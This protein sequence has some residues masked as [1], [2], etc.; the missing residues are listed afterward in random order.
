MRKARELRSLMKRQKERSASM[1]LVSASVSSALCLTW[2]DEANSQDDLWVKGPSWVR[3]MM[4][5]GGQVRCLGYI[6]PQGLLSLHRPACPPGYQSQVSTNRRCFTPVGLLACFSQA[7]GALGY[8]Q[9]R[10]CL[11]IQRHV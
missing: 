8:T 3:G 11:S 10:S 4:H 7:L 9:D 6:L 2:W 5:A 1:T